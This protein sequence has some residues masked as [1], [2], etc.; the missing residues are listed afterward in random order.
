MTKLNHKKIQKINLAVTKK[1][2]QYISGE[3]E[4]TSVMEELESLHKDFFTHNIAFDLWL[5]FDFLD[6]N[7]HS[8]IESF[9]NKESNNLKLDEIKVLEARN[10]SNISLFEIIDIKDGF[11]R[12]NNLLENHE[13]DIWEEDLAQVVNVG[14]LIFSRTANLLGLNT[15]VGS[16]SY[17]PQSVRSRFLRE[18]FL[19]FNSLRELSPNLHMKTYL[20]NHSINLY[21][22]YT[23]CVFEAVELEYDISSVFYDEI[24]EFQSYL[25]TRETSIDKKK[26]LANLIEFFEYYLADEDLSLY[27]MDEVDLELFFYSSIEDGFI[28]S[29]EILNSYIYSFKIYL[30]FLSNVDK[31]YKDSYNTMISISD[32]RFHFMSLLK[33]VKTPFDIDEEFCNAIKGDF[34]DF[35]S[36]PIIDFDKFLLYMINNPMEVTAKTKNIKRIHLL[37]INNMLDLSKEVKNKAPNQADFPLIGLYYN[38]SIFLGLCE[39]EK[40]KMYI[41]SKGTGFLRLRDEEKFSMFFHYIWSKDFIK[42][43]YNLEG[44]KSFERHKKDLLNFLASLEADR[45]YEMFKVFPKTSIDS[46]FFFQYYQYLK[47]IGIIDYSLYPSYEI[48]ISQIGK[49]I[50]DYLLAKNKPSSKGSIIEIKSL[51]ENKVWDN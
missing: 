47:F 41:T 43:I 3:M 32:R 38:I 29:N 25:D 5:S 12:T 28:I 44:E 22:I 14:D 2:L 17:L 48:S 19:D 8:F 6:K 27:N 11:I 37:E 35:H 7:G 4:K 10:A 39:I 46:E 20:K 26:V 51:R 36:I 9:L 49:T 50:I 15:F 13:E 16:I 31:K 18:V 23:N 45:N 21:T 42:T 24:E 33:Q 30:G 34:N 1:L 40:N